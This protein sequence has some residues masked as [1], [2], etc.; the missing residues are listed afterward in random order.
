ARKTFE[1]GGSGENLP[2]VSVSAA[3]LSAGISIVQALID[4][5]FA[6]SKSDARRAIQEGSVKLNDAKVSD[7]EKSIT[8]T[9]VSGG[10]AK[11]SRGKKRHGL[12]KIDA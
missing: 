1:E 4:L 2:S 9:D 7:E 10:S 6:S 3:N 5:G 12:L 8:Q 11:I